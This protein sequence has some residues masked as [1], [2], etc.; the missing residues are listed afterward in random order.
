MAINYPTSLDNG[1]SLP[2]P[3]ST[4]T[5]SS[6]NLSGLADNLNDAIIALETKLGI[7]DAN[8]QTPVAG[9]LLASTATGESSWSVPFP[10]ST[11]VGVSD[12]QTLTNKT[13]DFTNNTISNIAGAN[14][15]SQ[16]ITATQI[17]NATITATQIANATI[18][19]TQIANVTI[20]ANQIANATITATQ[21]ANSSVAT[22]YNPYKFSV[23]RAAAYTT[24]ADAFTLL[25]FDT[26]NYDSGSN[27][28]TSTD[29]FTAPVAGFYRFDGN[30]QF[31]EP[32]PRSFLSIYVNGVEYMRGPDNQ[33]TNAGN[34]IT[35]T[36]EL[37][38]NDTV[39]L[40]YYVT[41]AVALTNSQFTQ[42]SGQLV[43]AT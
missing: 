29:V 10:A 20:T 32:V 9:N 41:S 36:M 6:P 8:S 24:V 14:I 5:L 38:V 28:S 27:F 40:Y 23:Y 30:I 21:I 2:Y 7:A 4:D 33:S 35:I 17:A 37:A 12:T 43:S 11:I 25:P 39:S 42:F 16:S 31:S 13:I 18:T 3:S 1:T 15:A 26:V 34:N 19:A 22:L